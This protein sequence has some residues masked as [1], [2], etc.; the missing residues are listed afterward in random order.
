MTDTHIEVSLSEAKI[1][2]RAMRRGFQVMRVRGRESERRQ[3]SGRGDLML[4][5]DSK[6][7]LFTATLEDIAM[8]LKAH[9][10]AQRR[11]LN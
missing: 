8:F 7:V 4:I 2:Y 10:V 11:K 9:D 6:V 5:D 1:R 3:A